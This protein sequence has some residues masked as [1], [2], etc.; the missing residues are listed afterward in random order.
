VTRARDRFELRRGGLALPDERSIRFDSVS[1]WGGWAFRPMRLSK[2]EHV[3]GANWSAWLPTDLPL[4]VRA[5][6]AGDAM[7][8]AGVGRARKVKRFLSDAGVT[9]HARA[10]WPVVLAGDQIVWIPGVS[11][12]N[13]ATERSGRPGLAFTCELNS[14]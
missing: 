7:A 5:W 9:G 4:T 2:L 11:R 13:A 10:R 14:R 8:V 1:T 12:S 6:R 3:G